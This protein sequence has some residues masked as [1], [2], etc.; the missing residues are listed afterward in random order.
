MSPSEAAGSHGSPRHV[1]H[2]PA[3]PS[4]ILPNIGF[5]HRHDVCQP[6]SSSSG[7]LGNQSTEPLRGLPEV[8][9]Q[10]SS[11]A[12]LKPWEISASSQPCI[13]CAPPPSPVHH[14]TGPG[15]GFVVEAVGVI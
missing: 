6:F 13:P 2:L 12:G 4:H 11:R 9:Q 8:T 3:S 10:D 15:S 14:R 7:K 1:L 5:G